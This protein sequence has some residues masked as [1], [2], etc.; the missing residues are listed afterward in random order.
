M[1]ALTL[2]IGLAFYLLFIASI[3]RYLRHRGALELAVVLV[4][5]STAA[6]FASR[7]H[8]RLPAG[9]GSVSRPRCRHAPRGAAGPD[10]PPRGLHRPAS[11]LGGARR[12]RRLRR[13][14][15]GVLRHQPQRP[16]H[17]VPRRLLRGHGVPCGKRPDPG[18]PPAPRVPEVATHHGGH[19]VAAV[20]PVDHHLRARRQPAAG[21]GRAIPRSRSSP[22]SWR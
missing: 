15:P 4:F 1:D 20:R 19:R 11:A 17:P 14:R 12:G 22:A 3:V 5:S 18:S 8:Q 21:R 16:V 2:L 13:H 7:P 6:L 10:G 9:A